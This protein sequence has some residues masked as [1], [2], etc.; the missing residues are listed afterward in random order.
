MECVFIEH[1]CLECEELEAEEAL[2]AVQFRAVELLNEA[3]ERLRWVR[4][5]KALVKECGFKLTGVFS[6]E[7]ESEEPSGRS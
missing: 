1:C 5:Q 2:D 6:D 3:K 7:L 4:K